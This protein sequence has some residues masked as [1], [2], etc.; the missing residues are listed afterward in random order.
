M[1]NDLVVVE[2]SQRKA[3]KADQEIVIRQVGFVLSL[4]TAIAIVIRVFQI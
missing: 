4:I 1:Q 3:K 2:P